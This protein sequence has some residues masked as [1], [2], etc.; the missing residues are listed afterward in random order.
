MI[1]IVKEPKEV[2]DFIYEYSFNDKTASYPRMKSKEKITK[3]INR[4]LNMENRVMITCSRDDELFGVCCYHWDNAKYAQASIFLIRDKYDNVADEMINYI[5]AQLPEYE[6]LIGVPTTNEEAN[7]YFENM[8]FSCIESSIVMHQINLSHLERTENPQINRITK[9]NFDSYMGFHDKFAIPN[10]MYFTS[11]KLLE[12]IGGFDILT[13]NE[14]NEIFASI[15]A[16]KGKD[17]TDIIGV[18]IEENHRNKGIERILFDEL[19]AQL[20]D[21]FGEI[22]EVLYFAEEE[23]EVEVAM[24]AGFLVKESYKCYRKV[25]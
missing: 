22:G 18:F 24:E 9:I 17:L 16:S 25:L 10:E 6:L 14:G 8:K 3:N 12:A 23:H 2:Y 15:F 21:Q 13:F 7:Q 19:R 11:G 4:A 5:Q 1:K 20:I